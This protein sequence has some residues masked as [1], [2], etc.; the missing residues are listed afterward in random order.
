MRLASTGA[1]LAVVERLMASCNHRLSIRQYHG[2]R[3]PLGVADTE[4]SMALH[5]LAGGHEWVPGDPVVAA[6]EVGGAD[7]A[8]D[9]RFSI[10]RPLED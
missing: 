6:A 9:C 8:A 2:A 5:A 7:S 1:A 4:R 10:E 3:V